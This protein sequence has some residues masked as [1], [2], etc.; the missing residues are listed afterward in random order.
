MD[1]MEGRVAR[2]GTSTLISSPVEDVGRLPMED[3]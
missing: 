2:M 1:F 3:R